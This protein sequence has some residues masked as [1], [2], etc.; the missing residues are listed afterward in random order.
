MML[1]WG[2]NSVMLRTEH[3]KRGEYMF[4]STHSIVVGQVERSVIGSQVSF[5]LCE[6][7][8]DGRQEMEDFM[9]RAALEM[10]MSFISFKRCMHGISPCFFSFPHNWPKYDTTDPIFSSVSPYFTATERACVYDMHDS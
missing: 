2:D 5:L 7:I 3:K 10:Q 8:K 4:L 1:Q 9:L 6:K